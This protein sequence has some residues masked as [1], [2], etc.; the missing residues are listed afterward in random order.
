MKKWML[1]LL[2]VV[3]FTF[4]SCFKDEDTP[5]QYYDLGIVTDV[6]NGYTI[7]TDSK[8]TLFTSQ[9]INSTDF[10]M[11]EGMRVYFTYTVIKEGTAA[12]GYT[13]KISIAYIQKVTVSPIIPLNSVNRDTIGNDNV[14]INGLSIGSK[15]LNVDYGFYAYNKPHYFSLV[16][17]PENQNVTGY[18]VFEFRHKDNDDQMSGAARGLRSYDLST[19][20]WTGTAPYKLIFRF[21]DYNSKVNDVKFEYTPPTL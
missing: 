20:Q 19:F 8:D 3:T 14:A 7:L 9:S 17:D 12:D 10:T 2:G 21:K 15:Y 16:Y 18:T 5:T 11:T 1:L 6:F 4:T 13:K